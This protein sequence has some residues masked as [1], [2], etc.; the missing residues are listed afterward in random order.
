MKILNNKGPKIEPCGT[1]NNISLQELYLPFIFT[2]C[3]L[4]VEHM[5]P[6][7]ILLEKLH[8]CLHEIHPKYPLEQLFSNIPTILK[9]KFSSFLLCVQHFFV[10]VSEP[11]NNVCRSSFSLVFFAVFS[12]S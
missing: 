11:M 10:L 2:L 5:Q 1:P 4:P 12:A 9:G 3:V 6:Y 7:K 8:N